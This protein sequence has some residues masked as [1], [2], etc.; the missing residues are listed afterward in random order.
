MQDFTNPKPLIVGI[1]VVCGK[2][3]RSRHDVGCSDRAGSIR[4]GI[5]IIGSTFVDRGGLD[6]LRILRVHPAPLLVTLG[7]FRSAWRDGSSDRER[8]PQH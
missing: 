1:G 7:L 4:V 6:L 2:P 8:P 5:V 3:A